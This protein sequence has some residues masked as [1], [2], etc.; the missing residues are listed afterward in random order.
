MTADETPSA[1]LYGETLK[2]RANSGVALARRLLE[3]ASV[4]HMNHAARR[5]NESRA[6]K[7]AERDAH[8]WSV[9]TEHDGEKLVA[10]R[11]LLGPDTILRFQQPPRA[12]VF[13][14]VQ[15]IAGRGPH[16]LEQ[17]RLGVAGE[18]LADGSIPFNFGA[19]RINRQREQTATCDLNHRFPD[20]GAV[21]QQSGDIGE[22]FASHRGDFHHGAVVHQ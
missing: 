8:G 18:Q 4:E 16:A 12:S 2:V 17:K 21:V 15:R 10:E 20:S 3:T 19:K 22:P 6:L 13:D 9:D 5:M 1:P 7:S 14:V 11:E